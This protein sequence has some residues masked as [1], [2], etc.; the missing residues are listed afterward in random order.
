MVVQ[1]HVAKFHMLNWELHVILFTAFALVEYN[2]YKVRGNGG[3]LK[4]ILLFLF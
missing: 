3:D 4:H 1:Y 2:L